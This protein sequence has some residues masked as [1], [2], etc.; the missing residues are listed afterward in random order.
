MTTTG[1]FKAISVQ[2][3]STSGCAL[4]GTAAG[5][6]AAFFLRFG[7][8]FVSAVFLA[9]ARVTLRG[10]RPF[11]RSLRDDVA[12]QSSSSS[13]LD[14]SSFALKRAQI[15]VL[16]DFI[17]PDFGRKELWSQEGCSSPLITLRIDLFVSGLDSRTAHDLSLEFVPAI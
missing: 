17:L 16:A 12:S 8:G 14:A 10:P 11:R 9:D 4:D 2:S 7:D 6:C 13:S 3:R 5:F 1:V 15:V